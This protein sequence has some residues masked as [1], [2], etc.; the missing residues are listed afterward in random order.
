MVTGHKHERRPLARASLKAFTRQQYKGGVLKLLIV[1]DGE[2]LLEEGHDF[3]NVQ[4]TMIKPAGESLGELRQL[5]MAV[6]GTPY[7]MQWDDDDHPTPMRVQWQVNQTRFAQGEA[8]IFRKEIHCDIRTGAA[9]VNNG[10]QSRVNG[11]AGT[12]LFPRDPRITFP[13]TGKHEDTEFLL[14]YK[15]QG[16]LRVLENDPALYLRFYHGS[17][18]WSEKHVMN[19]KPGWRELD[20]MERQM[21]DQI[22]NEDYAEMRQTD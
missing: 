4:E 10:K 11:F 16:R 7:I 14:Q 18:T 15:R 13:E 5:G 8:T 22:L 1:N 17:N 20:E 12:M 19:R 3:K 6:A 21:L 9:F 2:P